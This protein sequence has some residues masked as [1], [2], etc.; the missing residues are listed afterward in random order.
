MP[1]L[2][3]CLVFGF[4]YIASPVGEVVSDQ[5]GAL[6]IREFLPNSDVPMEAAFRGPIQDDNFI[7][8]PINADTARGCGFHLRRVV[9]S[10]LPILGRSV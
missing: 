2:L 9:E 6:L 1:C 5:R 3:S 7:V 8:S 10:R 4:Y